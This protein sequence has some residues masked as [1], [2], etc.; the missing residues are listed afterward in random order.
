MKKR[1]L[2]LI[3]FILILTFA[4]SCGANGDPVLAVSGIVE[5][6][7]SQRELEALHMIDSEYTNKDGDTTIFTGI[8]IGDILV[9]A[10]VSE[11]SKISII[12]SDGY[13]AEITYEE[14]SACEDCILA[15]NEYD[16]WSA[17]MPGFSSKLQVRDIVELNIQ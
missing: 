10:K 6:S 14:L 1:K 9:F 7:C 16:G 8:A 13:F 5:V 15:Y 11:Y 2:F 3:A 17:V 4:V 12:A